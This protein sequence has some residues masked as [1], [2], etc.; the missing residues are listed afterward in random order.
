MSSDYYQSQLSNIKLLFVPI[1]TVQ[2]FRNYLELA[3]YEMRTKILFYHR[4]K[5][6]KKGIFLPDF[7]LLCMHDLLAPYLSKSFRGSITKA[8]IWTVFHTGKVISHV[9]IPTAPVQFKRQE[10]AQT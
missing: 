4:K 3:V 1:L 5:R 10:L 8:K 9:L 7:L 2:G 6:R